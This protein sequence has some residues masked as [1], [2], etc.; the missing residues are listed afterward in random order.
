MHAEGSQQIRLKKVTWKKIK[1]RE[2]TNISSKK[3]TKYFPFC[4]PLFPPEVFAYLGRGRPGVPCP[5]P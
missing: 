2:S 4:G 1:N 3:T 5:L